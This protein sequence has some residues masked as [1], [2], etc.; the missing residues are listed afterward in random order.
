MTYD[1]V[2]VVQYTNGVQTGIKALAGIIDYGTHGAYIAGGNPASSGNAD[3][4]Q[5]LDGLIDELQIAAEVRSAG[6]ILAMLKSKI[7]LPVYL[8]SP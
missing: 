4:Y 6:D 3:P 5:L 1:G 8:G 7:D 2:N